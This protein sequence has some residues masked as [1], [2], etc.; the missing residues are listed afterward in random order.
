MTLLQL[1]VL[2]IGLKFEARSGMKMTS[3]VNTYRLAASVLGY[4]VKAR[5]AKAE[6][7]EGLERLVNERMEL[8][9]A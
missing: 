4:P 1:K 7:I 8:R 2:L 3:K 5:P 9:G 6:L